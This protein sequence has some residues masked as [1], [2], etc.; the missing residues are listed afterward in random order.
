M[1]SKQTRKYQ[2][3]CAREGFELLGIER[4]GKHCR[5]QF[6]AGFVTVPVTPSDNRNMMNVRAEIRRLHR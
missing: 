2:R 4:G 6:E 3:M 5:L 1:A